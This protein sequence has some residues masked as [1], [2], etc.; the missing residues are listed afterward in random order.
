MLTAIILTLNEARHI[1]ECI[2]SLGFAQTV[3]VFD[4]GSTDET[5]ALARQ[6]GAQIIEYPFANYPQ[7]RNAALDAADSEWV[8]FVD[9]DERIPPALAEEIQATLAAPAHPGYWIP[10]HNYIFGKL[11]RHT[12]WY[13]DYQMR[14]LRRAAARYD[15]ARPVHEL[16]ILQTG[17]A[18]Y[19]SNPLVH[20]NYETLAQFHAKQQ[21]YTAFDAQM[22]YN[23]GV[24]PKI[25]T[26]YTQPLRH[27]KWRFWDLQ[28]YKDGWHGFRLSVLMAWYE[29]R[30][31]QQ[32]RA[33]LT[34]AR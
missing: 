23:E 32:V 20:Y 21:R 25:Y 14:L 5:Q 13:P 16:V 12:G 3:L 11:T 30:K 10:R 22:L 24:R 7:Q 1:E 15:D 17:E 34:R 31:Y 8:L 9:A 28:G 33:L 27:F 26:P 4:S 19:L 6:A 18:G 29:C 2:A